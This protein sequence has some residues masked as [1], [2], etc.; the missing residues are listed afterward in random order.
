MTVAELSKA[1]ND[2]RELGVAL[3]DYA[4]QWVGICDRQVIAHAATLEELVEQ[5]EAS[6]LEE[7]EVIQVP[8]DPAAACF[9]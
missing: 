7:V 8:K 1:L 6:G 2:E 9:Y 5:V 3:D 4:G